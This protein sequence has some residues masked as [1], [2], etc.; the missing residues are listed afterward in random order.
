M[1]HSFRP[2]FSILLVFVL[3]VLQVAGAG[4]VTTAETLP[5]EELANYFVFGEGTWWDYVDYIDYA[6]S[7]DIDEESLAESEEDATYRVEDT[8]CPIYNCFVQSESGF[9]AK[10]YVEEDN[11]YMY[12][13]NGY[14]IENE[15][16]MLSLDG[17]Y[18]EISD[19]RGAFFGYDD[20]TD[21]TTLMECGVDYADG[22]LQQTC[23]YTFEKAYTDDVRYQID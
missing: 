17:M 3:S 7:Y 21:Y 22:L 12:E 18:A 11:I 5:E 16:M 19:L 20:L 13:V 2:L 6:R 15:L 10:Y 14:R 4:A 23:I 1:K 9:T 8:G